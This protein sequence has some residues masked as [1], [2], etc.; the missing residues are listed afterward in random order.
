MAYPDSLQR[1]LQYVFWKVF[2]PAHPHVRDLLTSTGLVRRRGRQKYLFGKIAPHRTIE[3]LVEHLI[4]HGWGKHFVA[5][6]EEGEIVGLRKVDGFERQYHLRIF[7]DGEVRGHYESTPEC[8]PITHLLE[9]A[10]EERR[11]EFLALLDGWIIS[12]GA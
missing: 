10:S 8:Y 3:S 1:K 7:D 12:H 11:E 6:R 9:A 5:W 4:K 2:T